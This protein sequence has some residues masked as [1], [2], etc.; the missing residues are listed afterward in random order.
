MKEADSQDPL[1]DLGEINEVY[2][3]KILNYKEAALKQSEN[4]GTILK[5]RRIHLS[6]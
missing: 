1:A 4:K 2:S 5:P 3:L 6:T